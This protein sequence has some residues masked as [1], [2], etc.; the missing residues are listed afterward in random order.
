MDKVKKIGFIAIVAVAAVYV[1]NKWIAPRVGI[2][3]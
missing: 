2:S 3:A 1:W